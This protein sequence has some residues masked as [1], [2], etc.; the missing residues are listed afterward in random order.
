VRRPGKA[1][2]VHG[3]IDL[4][5]KIL[6]TLSL[7]L[8][9]P[10]YV[11]YYGPA[12]F[13]WFS[14]IAFILTAVALWSESRLLASTMGVGVL[15]P[16]LLWNVS[17][18]GR[19][20]GRVRLTDLAGYMFDAKIPLFLRSLSLFHV[21]LPIVLLWMIHTLGYDSRALAVQ[22][23]FAWIIL[24]LTYGLTDPAKNINWV[25]GPGSRPQERISPRLYLG[26][27]M[28]FMPVCVYVPTHLVLQAISGRR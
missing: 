26:L 28:L 6:Y 10:V 16:E 1:T 14:D 4:W 21:A 18:F 8:V 17:F 23:L 2:V 24:P 25:F 3:D 9:L 7:A 27:L 20:I 22:S 19:L 12:N 13:L 5:V 11:V 15:L